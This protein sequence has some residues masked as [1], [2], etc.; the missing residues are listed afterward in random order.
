MLAGGLRFL[1]SVELLSEYRR[2]L[3]RKKI[4]T[5][6]GLTEEQIDALLSALATS[7]VVADIAGRAET[8]PDPGDNH[9]WRLLAV[10]PAAGLITGDALLLNNPPPATRVLAPRDWLEAQIT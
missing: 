1:L 7:A 6:H 8:A 3:L 2:V 9:L 10:R 4:R 5:R